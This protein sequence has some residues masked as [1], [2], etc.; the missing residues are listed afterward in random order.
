LQHLSDDDLGKWRAPTRLSAL[1][2]SA[3]CTSWEHMLATYKQ[4][5]SVGINDRVEADEAVIAYQNAHSLHV[6]AQQ[7][8]AAFA[9]SKSGK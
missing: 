7:A 5:L 4:A 8:V 9:D 3:V 1:L 6:A 2:E